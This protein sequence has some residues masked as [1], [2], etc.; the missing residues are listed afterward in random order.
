MKP[1]SASIIAEKFGFTARHWIR[2]AASGKVPGAYQPSGPRGA[3]CFDLTVFEKWWRAQCREVASWPAYT[4][5]EKNGG[6]APSVRAGNTAE[7]SKQRI[8]QLLGN[9]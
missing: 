6:A 9:V 7:A 2:L 4:N 1:V 8:R 5:V 3:W